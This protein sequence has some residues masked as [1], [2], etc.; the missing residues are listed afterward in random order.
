MMLTSKD[1]Q[2]M[3]RLGRGAVQYPEA[4]YAFLAGQYMAL[5]LNETEHRILRSEFEEGVRNNCSG[6]TQYDNAMWALKDWERYFE[7]VA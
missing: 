5:A 6:M 2:D 3:R 1:L 7:E 4:N